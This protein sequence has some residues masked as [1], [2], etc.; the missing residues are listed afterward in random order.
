MNFSDTHFNAL[1]DKEFLGYRETSEKVSLLLED[2]GLEVENYFIDTI[3]DDCFENDG[4]F[5]YLVVEKDELFASILNSE[6]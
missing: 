6:K 2:L 3:I 1:A 5:Y 4:V